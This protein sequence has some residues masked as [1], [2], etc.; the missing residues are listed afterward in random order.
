MRDRE[1]RKREKVEIKRARVER[2]ERT[3]K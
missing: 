2:R 1:G 3:K